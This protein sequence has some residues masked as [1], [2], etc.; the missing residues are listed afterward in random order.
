[1]S[2]NIL[3]PENLKT[4]QARKTDTFIF[5]IY[6]L[7]TLSVVKEYSLLKTKVRHLHTFN[8]LSFHS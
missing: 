2:T 4:L 5:L 8:K 1:M 3:T 6:E 7:G